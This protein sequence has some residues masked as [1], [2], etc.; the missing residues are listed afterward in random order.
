M[1]K[2]LVLLLLAACVLWGCARL[3]GEGEQAVAVDVEF[4][5]ADGLFKE[6][7]Y[8]EAIAVYAKIARESA[9][10]Q[11][12]ANALFASASTHVFYNNPQKE[13]S[14]A[15][16]EF[17]EFLRAYPNDEKAEEARNWRYFIKTLLELRKENEHLNKNI[18]ELKRIDIR[19]EE[20][21]QGK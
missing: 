19:H 2:L 12:G 16:Q 3:R 6:K 7:H 10:S 21:R 11:R 15:L 5:D 4:R 1:K 20:R 14:L 17:D 18:E 13:Y 8:S 9:G